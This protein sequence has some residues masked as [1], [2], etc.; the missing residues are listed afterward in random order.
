MIHHVH[1]QTSTEVSRRWLSQLNERI[2]RLTMLGVAGIVAVSPS[3]ERYLRRRGY[4]SE[5]LWLVPN[6]VATQPW[7]DK[8]QPDTWTIGTVAMFRPRKGVETLLHAV[9]ELRR[10][11]LPVR[12]RAVGRFQTPEYEAEV[13]QLTASLGLTDAVDWTG[14]CRD[15][16]A[17]LARM[18]IFVLPSLISE[19]MPMSVLE[20]MAAGIPVVGSRVDG[21]TDLVRDGQDGLLAAPGDSDDLA[22]V[23]ARMVRGD[24]DWRQMRHSA[25]QRQAD[26][27]SDASMVR[28]RG[29]LSHRP[30]KK[31]ALEVI[32]DT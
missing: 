23:L 17:E 10:Q 26:R 6:G 31:I 30:R 28:H 20:A 16:N 13:K 19:A 24:A 18:D 25:W 1:C 27:F 32:F 9:A 22:A 11:G 7:S 5:R 4:R 29:R 3:L 14:F 2:E 8:D 15:V 12:L 21:I